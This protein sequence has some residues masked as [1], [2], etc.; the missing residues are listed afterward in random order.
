MTVWTAMMGLP[1]SEFIP[2]WTRA[3]VD[4]SPKFL[5]SRFFYS[6]VTFP[7]WE[8]EI[9]NMVCEATAARKAAKEEAYREMHTHGDTSVSNLTALNRRNRF[10]VVKNDE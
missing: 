9:A 5:R 3:E 1:A 10:R 7:N 4:Y 6:T 2:W 8:G